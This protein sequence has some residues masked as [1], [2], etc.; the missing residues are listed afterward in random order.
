[1]YTTDK[2]EQ[3]LD[4]IRKVFLLYERS[5]LKDS[6]VMDLTRKIVDV[7]VTKSVLSEIKGQSCKTCLYYKDGFCYGKKYAPAVDPNGFCDDWE[8]TISTDINKE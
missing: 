4:D 2:A 5:I 1:M 7:Y 8:P 3:A 6:D